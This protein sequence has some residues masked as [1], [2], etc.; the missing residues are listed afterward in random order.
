MTS[1][2]SYK[3]RGI[4]VIGINFSE[5]LSMAIWQCSNQLRYLDACVQE[6]KA[7]VKQCASYG[8][9]IQTEVLIYRLSVRGLQLIFTKIVYFFH[10]SDQWNVLDLTTLIIYLVIFV[11]RMVTWGLSNSVENDRVLLITGYLYGLST[12]ILTFRAF[13]HMMEN[14]REVGSIQIALFHIVS[15]VV[16]IFW[17]F[18]A[19]ILAFSIAITKV[20]MAEK[21]YLEKDNR[22]KNT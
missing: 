11:L 19:A 4:R 7:S 1:K 17:Q 15:D 20:Y 18:I 2:W 8:V 13:G 12:L 5:F 22:D 21:S 16:A 6:Q 9:H 10:C 14:T 3:N